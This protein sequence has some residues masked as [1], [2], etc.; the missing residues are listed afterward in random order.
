MNQPNFV[1]IGATKSGTTSLWHYLNAHPQ[2]FMSQKKEPHYFVFRDGIPDYQGPRDRARME[3]QAVTGEKEYQALFA[4]GVGHAARGEASAMYLYFPEA[5]EAM[6]ADLPDARLIAILRNPVDRAYSA[7]CHHVRDG[8]ET[9]TFEDAIEQDLRGAR[10]TW[11][12]LWHYAKMGLY[13]QQLERFYDRVPAQQIRV[14][15]YD[16]LRSAPQATLADIHRFLDVAEVAPGGASRRFNA[17]GTPRS[18]WLH[19]A[20]TEPSP[21]KTAIRKVTPRGL[22]YPAVNLLKSRNLKPSPP[23]PEAARRLLTDYYRDDLLALQCLLGR[24]LGHWLTG[25]AS[26]RKAS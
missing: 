6:H 1:I 4:R 3:H 5:A 13:H 11:M 24:D 17:S 14:Y 23:M 12:P 25:S 16:D 21:L 18:R 15:L 2:V 10:D 19:R 20:L 9:L 8:V 22:L 26:K 7:Y